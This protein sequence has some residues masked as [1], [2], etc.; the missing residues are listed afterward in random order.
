MLEDQWNLFFL[1]EKCQGDPPYFRVLETTHNKVSKREEI[2][3]YECLILISDYRRYERE[4][5]ENGRGLW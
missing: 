1:P 4:A 2:L 3:Y 5:R